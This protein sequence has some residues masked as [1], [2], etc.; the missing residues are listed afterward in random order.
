MEVILNPDQPNEEVLALRPDA[1]DS[2]WEGQGG[3]VDGAGVVVQVAYDFEDEPYAIEIDIAHP[4]RK[5]EKQEMLARANRKHVPGAINLGQVGRGK[6]GSYAANY[7]EN[8]LGE[9]VYGGTYQQSGRKHFGSEPHVDVPL[10]LAA[11]TETVTAGVQ[12]P[13]DAPVR[14]YNISAI[15]AYITL[16]QYQDFFPGYMFVL[17]EDVEKVR[18]EEIGRASCRERV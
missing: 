6:A 14:E 16:N 1:T 2:Y 12:G 10:T 15:N 7:L 18:A 11:Q 9:K 13:A 5:I 8:K 3:A 4:L 17:T